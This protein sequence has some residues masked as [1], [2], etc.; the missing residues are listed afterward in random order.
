MLN[1]L[2]SLNVNWLAVKALL[3]TLDYLKRNCQ[4]N[5][6]DSQQGGGRDYVLLG[7]LVGACCH[8]L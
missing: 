1:N 2:K 4:Q 7:I 3:S 6:C 8:V 5:K